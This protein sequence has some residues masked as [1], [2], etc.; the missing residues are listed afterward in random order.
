MLSFKEALD[1]V[2]R[3]FDTIYERCNKKFQYGCGSY[4]FDGRTYQYYAGMQPK[5]ELLFN[6]AKDVN[7]VLEIGTY[8]GHSA[9]IMLTANPS[10]E[11]TMIDIDPTYSIPASNLLRE[12]FPHA[13]I[14][15]IIGDSLSTLPRLAQDPSKKFDLF[16]IDGQHAERIVLSEYE[17]CKHLTKNKKMNVIFDDVDCCLGSVK[18][19][20]S[21]SETEKFIIPDCPWRNAHLITHMV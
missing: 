19:I 15:L 12:I 16:H 11:M 10:L 13:K 4:L 20:A 8:M 6:A 9:L 14:E 1:S 2:Q 7:S 17:L 3:S 18:L 5:Q 21:S